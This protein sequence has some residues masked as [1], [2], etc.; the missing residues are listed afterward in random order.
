MKSK[1]ASGHHSISN[2]MINVILP[3]SSSF[4]VTLFNKILQTQICPEEWSRGIISPVPKSEEIENPGNYCSI[5]INS[6]LSELF[7][8]LILCGL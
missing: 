3:S 4:L 8:L 6:C 2:E 1:K 5:T 7:N